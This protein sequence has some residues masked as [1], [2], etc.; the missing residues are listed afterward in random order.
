MKKFSDFCTCTVAMGT[1]VGAFTNTNKKKSTKANL[2]V[3]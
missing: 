2:Q 1:W 3:I